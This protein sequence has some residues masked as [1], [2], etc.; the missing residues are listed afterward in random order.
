[1]TKQTMLELEKDRTPFY[2]RLEECKLPLKD[3]EIEMKIRTCDGC[4][5]KIKCAIFDD[6]WIKIDD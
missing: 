3:N 5:I 1:M 4:M 6:D 2:T